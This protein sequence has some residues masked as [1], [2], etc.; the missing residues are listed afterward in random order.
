MIFLCV[1]ALFHLNKAKHPVKV[2]VWGEISWHGIIIFEGK[3]NAEGFIEVLENG[4]LPFIRQV[5]LD[6]PF[7]LDSDPKHTS[8][9]EANVITFY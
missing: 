2:Y 7:M 6:H 3:M 5:L 1:Y 8:W 4:C 9:R